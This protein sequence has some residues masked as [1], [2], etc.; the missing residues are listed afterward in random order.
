MRI[1]TKITE[2]KVGDRI[3][4]GT[5]TSIVPH[6]LYPDRYLSVTTENGTNPLLVND[7]IEVIR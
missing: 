5:I 1:R 2:L 4:Y 3:M 6:S 7:T